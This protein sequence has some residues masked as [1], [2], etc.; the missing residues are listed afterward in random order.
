M[1]DG[2]DVE[3]LA[4]HPDL[5]MPPETGATFEENAR[6]KAEHAARALGL[7]A[8]AD[9]SG[10]EVD[11]LGGAPGVRSARYAPGTDADRVRKLLAALDGVPEG[12]RTARFR[13]AM[14]FAADGMPT[15]ITH[16]GCEGR[17]AVA[18]RGA[19]G[20]GYD[21]VF[22]LALDHRTMAELPA[23]EKNARSH[24]SAA[25]TGMRPVLARYFSLV[26]GR[27]E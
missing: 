4:D 24:R 18:P 19:G 13:C 21:P 11:A 1:L 16:G 20:F 15:A 8:L 23:D 10:L 9:D 25:L 27:G 5:V 22:V 12:D 2:V 3:T 26:R 6:L 17:I 14:A 7:P